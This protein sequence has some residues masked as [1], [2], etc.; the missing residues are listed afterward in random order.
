[1]NILDKSKELIKIINDASSVFLV[2]HKDLDL[3][4]INSCI[5]FDFYLKSLKKKSYIIIDD[6]TREIGVKKVLEQYGKNIKE[7][8]SKD[9]INIKDDRS[10][11]VVLDTNKI[12][13]LQN[14]EVL[15]L[16]DKIIN[17]DHHDKTKDSL[18]AT[19]SI[20]DTKSSSTCEMIATYLKEKEI[21]INGK[22]ATL[23]LA[24]I[25]LDTNYYRQKADSTTFYMSYYLTMCGGDV[26]GVNELLKHDIKDY[27]KRQKMIASVKVINHVA[28]GKGSQRTTYKKEEVA[29]TADSLLTF[30]KIKASLVVAK[31]DKY[32]IS[33]SGRSTGEINIGKVLE[34]FGGGGNEYEGA[35]K[36]EESSINK[37]ID[38]LYKIVR[39]L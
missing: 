17:I 26:N 21:K 33:I 18:K 25:I 22:L 27:I 20:I 36:I 2:A 4:A 3:D 10:I 23:L 1:M 32:L 35:A 13:L 38:E 34:K 16:F 37:V 9:V 28:I 19:L 39:S 29:K 8:R 6:K 12:K 14:P 24:G 31:V 11:L 7:I 30:N 5:G 15:N